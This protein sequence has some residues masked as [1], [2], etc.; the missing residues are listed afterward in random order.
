MAKSFKRSGT[1]QNYGLLFVLTLAACSASSPSNPQPGASGAA[2][3]TGGGAAPVGTG[4]AGTVTGSGGSG[5]GVTA[6]GPCQGSDI[7]LHKRLVRLSFNQISNAVT[8]L[9]NAALGATIAATYEIGDSEHRT[10]PPLASPREGSTLTDSTWAKGDKIA[11]DVAKYVI[12]NV[13]TVTNCGAAPSA[14]CAKAFVL[15]FAERA[16]RRPLNDAE[17]A[18]LVKVLADVTAAG[19]SASEQLQYGIYAVLESPYFLYRTEFGQDAGQAGSLTPHEVASQLAFFLTD[20][21]PDKPLLDAAAQ[22]ALSTPEQVSA[23]VKRIVA[24]PEAKQNLQDAMFS[25]FGLYGLEKV[26]VDS[27]D[28]TEPVR[29][30]MLHESELFLE[31][32]LWSPK[33]SSLLNGRQSTINATLAPLYGVPAPTTGLDA[34]GFALVDLPANRAGI[35]TNLGFLTARSRPDQPSVV[36]RGLLVNAALLC[37]VNP[38]FPKQLADQIAAASMMLAEASEREKSDYR[39]STTPCSGC[40]KAF[41]PYG[42]ALGNFDTVGRFQTMDSKGRAIDAAVTLPPTAGSAQVK[43]AT[44]M[45]DAL[46]GGGTFAACMA[47]NVM[48]YALAEVPDEGASVTSVSVNGCATQSIAAGFVKTGQS[49][50]DLVEQVAVSN[51]LGQRSAGAK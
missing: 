33:L 9:T 17:Q 25:Y 13:A 34:D 30:S 16:F 11:A 50:S 28:F 18:N 24:L 48:L 23:Q 31:N 1:T 27:P 46:A 29:N 47:K 21:P 42:L 36:G 4:G 19:G 35:L 6:L 43:S 7:P 41:D 32:T 40:H 49:F 15:A 45:A 22:G 12:D 51:T 38:E 39:T 26:V 44:E 10:F 14:D 20:T 3:P 2:G 8:S 37:A 5:S